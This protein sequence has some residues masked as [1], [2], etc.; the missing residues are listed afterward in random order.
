MKLTASRGS[1]S[2]S[3][4][5]YTSLSCPA[6][7]NPSTSA[8]KFLGSESTRI[9]EDGATICRRKGGRNNMKNPQSITT[10]V[11]SNVHIT[12]GAKDEFR[13]RLPFASLD[14]A[15]ASSCIV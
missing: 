6:Y 4:S 13:K 15:Q 5:T 12:F 3:K 7:H 14:Q 9:H 8:G 10:A 1:K 11:R 2:G